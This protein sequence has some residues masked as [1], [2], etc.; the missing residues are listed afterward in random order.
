L[1]RLRAERAA[2]LLRTT[3]LRIH[4]IAQQ[5]GIQDPFQ[6]SRL[7]KRKKGLSPKAYRA[8]KAFF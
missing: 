8:A 6:F 2:V 7:I 3:S 5:V 4:E 1:A